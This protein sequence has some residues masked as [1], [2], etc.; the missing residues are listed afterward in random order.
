MSRPYITAEELFAQAKLQE[1][2]RDRAAKFDVPFT[3]SANSEAVRRDITREWLEDA[4]REIN[5]LNAII[6]H[7]GKAP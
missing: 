4:A 1:A 5:R 6:Y 2:A 3:V 7:L